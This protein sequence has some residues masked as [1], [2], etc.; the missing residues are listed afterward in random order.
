MAQGKAVGEFEFLFLGSLSFDFLGVEADRLCRLPFGACD[1]VGR[2]AAK[3]DAA[4]EADLQV[5]EADQ[6]D[7]QEPRHRGGR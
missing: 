3:L 4:E 7:A 2:R 5:G 1:S 6:R